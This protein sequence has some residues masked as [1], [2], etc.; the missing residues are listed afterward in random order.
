MAEISCV[1]NAQTMDSSAIWP[2][3]PFAF[4]NRIRDEGRD[5][6]KTGTKQSSSWA[7]SASFRMAPK[8]E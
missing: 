8:L 2:K 7:K 4:S 3:L 5:H 6:S 1:S